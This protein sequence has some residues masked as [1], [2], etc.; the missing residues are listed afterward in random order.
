M[1]VLCVCTPVKECDNIPEIKASVSK[2]AHK[3]FGHFKVSN[4]YTNPEA[5]NN[6]ILALEDDKVIREINRYTREHT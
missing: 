5:L 4:S 3:I 6:I 1:C 2:E